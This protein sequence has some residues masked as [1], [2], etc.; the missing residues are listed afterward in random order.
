MVRT[1]FEEIVWTPDSSRLLYAKFVSESGWGSSRDE[2]WVVAV[3]GGT[4][5]SLN[6]TSRAMWHLTIH[7]DGRQL[8]YTS[9]SGEP[10][11]GIWVM[12]NFLP[13]RKDKY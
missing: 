12:E 5:K 2:L 3:S 11:A 9:T 8:A 6:L 1:K 7:P 4:P 13:D 10:K